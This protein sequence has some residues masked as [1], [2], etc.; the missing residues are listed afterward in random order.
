MCEGVDWICLVYDRRLLQA[1]INAVTNI[2]ELQGRKD[3]VLTVWLCSMELIVVGN[4]CT[5]FVH[6]EMQ[7]FLW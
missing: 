3:G 7:C 1:V 2:R 4:V 6:I 5:F